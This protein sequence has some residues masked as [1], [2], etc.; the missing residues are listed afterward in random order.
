MRVTLIFLKGRMT[1]AG[2]KNLKGIQ[3]FSKES[4]SRRKT[5]LVVEDD[6]THR[7]FMDKILKLCEFETEQAFNGL[8]ALKKLDEGQYFDLILMDWDMPELNG[9]DT[10]KEIR[11]RELYEGIEHVPVIAFTSNQRPGDRE[12]CIAAGMDAYLPKDTWMPRWRDILIDNLQGLVVGQFNLSDFEKAPP[13]NEEKKQAV[14]KFILD[15]FDMQA[16]LQSQSLLKSEFEIAIDEYLEDA[17]AYIKD[18]EAGI[19]NNS[20]EATARG[21]HPLKSN[22]KGFGLRAVSQIA[23][24]I[25]EQSRAGDFDAVKM[26]YP[27]L[28]EA[29]RIGEKRLRGVVEN[30]K[31]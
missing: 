17:A 14:R 8:E 6:R 10:V 21:S 3:P 28:R 29:F 16:L 1:V 5:I 18:I 15:D 25:N 13:K 27:Q 12:K 23:Q 24:E 22:S 2:D 7:A 31:R 11:R 19:E 26:L 20:L 9:L 30:G 4:S